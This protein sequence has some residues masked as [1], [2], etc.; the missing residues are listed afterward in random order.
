[1]MLPVFILSG[2]LGLSLHAV[3]QPCS[4]SQI[5][6]A[7]LKHAL[8][9][10]RTNV[11]GT[12]VIVGKGTYEGVEGKVKGYFPVFF[13]DGDCEDDGLPKCNMSSVI[14]ADI[15]TCR[16]NSGPINSNLLDQ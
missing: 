10:N 9:L 5:E 8:D 13:M 4:Q 14:F 12:K 2:F 16:V 3:A 7:A 15:S 1:M 6:K 11:H